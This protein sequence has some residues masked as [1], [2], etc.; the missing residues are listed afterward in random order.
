MKKFLFLS[1]IVAA[2]LFA[3]SLTA[4]AG[5]FDGL[6]PDPGK[7]GPVQT[8]PEAGSTLV[9]LGAA[10]MGITVLRRKLLK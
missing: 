1:K 9:L 10:L 7:N 5:A 8:V 4:S 2:V 3:S 6:L